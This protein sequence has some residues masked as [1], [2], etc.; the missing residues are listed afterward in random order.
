MSYP[1][2]GSLER[3]IAKIRELA[4]ESNLQ[5]DEKVLIEQAIEDMKKR[6]GVIIRDRATGEQVTYSKVPREKE[7]E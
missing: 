6:C 1:F 4:N 2:D 5:P 3:R 7:G